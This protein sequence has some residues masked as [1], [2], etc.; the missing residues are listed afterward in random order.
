M[1]WPNNFKKGKKEDLG[2]QHQGF[3][4]I[5]YP[6]PKNFGI[7]LLHTKVTETVDGIKLLVIYLR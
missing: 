5:S 7:Y 6:K 2:R 3:Q 1:P 4:K